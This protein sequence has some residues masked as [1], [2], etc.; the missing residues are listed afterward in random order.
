[1][2][3]DVVAGN[4]LVGPGA[5]RASLHTKWILCREKGSVFELYC[6]AY[7]DTLITWWLA[8]RL[9]KAKAINYNS[10]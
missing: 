1:M 7:V 4:D 6:R 9:K 5:V 10:I 8:H 2:K 3:E